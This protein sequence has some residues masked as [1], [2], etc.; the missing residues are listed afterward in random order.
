MLKAEEQK[1]ISAAQ[2]TTGKPPLEMIAAER[3]AQ[4]AMGYDAAHDDQHAAGELA[5]AAACFALG[6][7]EVRSAAHIGESTLLWPAEW[8]TEILGANTRMRQLVVAGALI[9]AEIE[10]LQ[11]AHFAA[12]DAAQAQQNT[13][14]T[15]EF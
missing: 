10:R 6:S 7:A 8:S 14:E 13:L 3:Q 12:I 1:R 9:A 5:A 2:R 4:L 15:L 11:R